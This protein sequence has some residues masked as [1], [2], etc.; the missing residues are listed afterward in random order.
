MP[1]GIL[2][3][4]SSAC[5]S[6]AQNMG[7]LPCTRMKMPSPTTFLRSIELSSAVKKR[8]EFFQTWKMR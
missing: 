4:G 8:F 3:A 6:S 5:G 1:A 2:R 7:W